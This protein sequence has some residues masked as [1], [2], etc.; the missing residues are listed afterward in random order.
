MHF[1]NKLFSITEK[2]LKPD[3]GNF[4]LRLNA[5]HPIY[6]GHFP[7]NPVTPGVCSMEIF[8]ELVQ[9]SF[10][11]C[12]RLAEVKS[13]KF[14]NFINPLNTP[15][16]TADIQLLEIAGG[17]WRV[18]GVLCADNKPAVKIVLRYGTNISQTI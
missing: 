9:H 11:G 2:K 15:E 18:R 6:R 5:S 3:S 13:V 17:M 12:G 1:T 16:L 10:P 14:L 4:R 8:K 7:D